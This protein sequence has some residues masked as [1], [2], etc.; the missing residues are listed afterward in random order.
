MD[1][2]VKSVWMILVCPLTILYPIQKWEMSG[3]N[4][5]TNKQAKTKGREKEG[6]LKQISYVP[7]SATSP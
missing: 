7:G 4:K 3:K 1:L 2:E 5:Q 6:A